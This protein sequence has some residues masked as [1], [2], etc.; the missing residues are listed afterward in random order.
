MCSVTCPYWSRLKPMQLPFAV[1]SKRAIGALP[2][3]ELQ[4]QP[5]RHLP[6]KRKRHPRR[7]SN[8]KTA[9]LRNPKRMGLTKVELWGELLNSPELRVTPTGLPVAHLN[10]ECGSEGEE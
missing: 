8:R 3:P 4:A 6:P 9:Q 7:K 2:R 5:P 10:L 1:R